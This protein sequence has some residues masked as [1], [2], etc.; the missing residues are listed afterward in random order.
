MGKY[1]SIVANGS[2]FLGLN[3]RG[4]LHL[5]QANPSKYE[6]IDRRALCEDSTWAHLAV[7]DDE[8]FVRELNAMVAY[9]W[10]RPDGTR[11][12]K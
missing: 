5:V 6:P 4:E 2:L 8:I 12:A 11:P 10:S 9:R 3:D 1:W 7:C